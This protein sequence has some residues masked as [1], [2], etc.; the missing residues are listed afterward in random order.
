MKRKTILT[1]CL[2]TVA[3]GLVAGGVAECRRSRREADGHA[4][5]IAPVEVSAAESGDVTMTAE[6]MAR[7]GLRR[8]DVESLLLINP[9]SR[10]SPPSFPAGV[11]VIW[12][13]DETPT[14]TVVEFGIHRDG[15]VKWRTAC[16]ERE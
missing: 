15:S 6:M 10:Y 16:P 11:D 3:M 7:N 1:V 5:A 4:T 8:P 14:P 12:R 2:L 13:F 9:A